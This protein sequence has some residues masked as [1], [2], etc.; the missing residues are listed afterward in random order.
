MKIRVN[1]LFYFMKNY[2]IELWF[3]IFYVDV[4][5]RESNECG[6][7]KIKRKMLKIFVVMFRGEIGG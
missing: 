5:K 4:S 7:F 1:D 6:Y 3:F 2:F